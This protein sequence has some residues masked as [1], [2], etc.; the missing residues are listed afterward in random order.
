MNCIVDLMSLN[1]DHIS[2]ESHR[3]VSTSL[4][5]REACDNSLTSLVRFMTT[6]MEC[7]E[8]HE[9]TADCRNLATD[10]Q[11][12]K[13]KLHTVPFQDCPKALYLPLCLNQLW[14]WSSDFTGARFLQS[15]VAA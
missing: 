5:A 14:F 12:S 13:T 1:P 6:S 4:Q 2:T 10:I 7:H 11:N 3:L 15:A 9:A 8:A